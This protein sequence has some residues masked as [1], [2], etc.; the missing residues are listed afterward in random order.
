MG[1]ADDDGEGWHRGVGAPPA[2]QRDVNGTSRG[3]TSILCV[4]V[5]R[6]RLAKSNAVLVLVLQVCMHGDDRLSCMRL[7]A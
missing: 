4:C 6:L 5:Q 1:R 7:A 3:Q 2:Q